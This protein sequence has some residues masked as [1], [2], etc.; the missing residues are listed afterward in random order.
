MLTLDAA[1]GVKESIP[2]H[3]AIEVAKMLEATNRA[4]PAA[5]YVEAFREAESDA[6]WEAAMPR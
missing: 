4:V 3:D 5:R 6:A 2:W 1:G